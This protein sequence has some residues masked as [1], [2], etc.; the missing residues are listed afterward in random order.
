MTD[1]AS[2]SEAD[3]NAIYLDETDLATVQSGREGMS[4]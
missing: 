2:V 4:K 1:L 3:R